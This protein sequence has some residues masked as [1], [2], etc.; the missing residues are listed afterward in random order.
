MILTSGL[1]NDQTMVKLRDA[2]MGGYLLGHHIMK[3]GK[4]NN[5]KLNN[6]KLNKSTKSKKDKKT[7]IKGGR[8]DNRKKEKVE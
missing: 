3:G 7:K 4:L 1:M 2:D 5:S 8:M 6:S